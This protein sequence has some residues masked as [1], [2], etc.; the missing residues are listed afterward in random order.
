MEPKA[1]RF[2]LTKRVDDSP[3]HEIDH[4]I[5]R[6]KCLAEHVIKRSN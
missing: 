1:I 2:S 4:T 3:K 5:K 6:N